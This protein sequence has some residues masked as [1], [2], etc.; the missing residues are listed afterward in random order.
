LGLILLAL[1]FMA[2]NYTYTRTTEHGW[3]PFKT[4]TYK[5]YKPY[6][7]FAPILVIIGIGVLLY[8]LAAKEEKK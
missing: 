2:S 1:A 8:G 7:Q 3:G 4:K 5:T 6:E